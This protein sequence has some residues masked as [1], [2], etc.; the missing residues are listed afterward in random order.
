MLS[1]K[2][3][4]KFQAQENKKVVFDELS[5]LLADLFIEQVFWEQQQNGERKKSRQA[6]EG[7]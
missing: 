1:D 7:P 3:I 5:D 2:D 6:D 4:A